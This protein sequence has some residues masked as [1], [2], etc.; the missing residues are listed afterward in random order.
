M[1]K[2]SPYHSFYEGMDYYQR[3]DYE[4]KLET[5]KPPRERYVPGHWFWRLIC[6]LL[7]PWP[8]GCFR[9]KWRRVREGPMHQYWNQHPEFGCDAFC[10]R[11]GSWW[12]DSR[13]G[14]MSV[15]ERLAAILD[16]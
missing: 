1:T 5:R 4:A 15:V 9:H 12:L 7:R 13:L 11:C 14:E 16:D 8:Y 6:W 10:R 2:D 3:Q